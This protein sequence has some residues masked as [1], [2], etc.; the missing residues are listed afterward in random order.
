MHKISCVSR[1]CERKRGD[2]AIGPWDI[3]SQDWHH[4]IW[5]KL[6]PSQCGRGG[7]RA[8]TNSEHYC[9]S[10]RNESNTSHRTEGLHKLTHD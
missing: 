7:G 3:D 4:E 8:T 1:I 10:Q 9:G 6:L 2:D 5:R